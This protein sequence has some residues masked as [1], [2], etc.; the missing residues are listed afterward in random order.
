M[1]AYKIYEKNLISSI[2]VPVMHLLKKWNLICF[3]ENLRFPVSKQY[4]IYV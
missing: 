3:S 1:I 2:N 4:K